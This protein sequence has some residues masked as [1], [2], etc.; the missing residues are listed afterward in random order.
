MKTV[1]KLEIVF[2]ENGGHLLTKVLINGKKAMLVVDTGAS[3]TVFD[4]T[5]IK[6]Y[7]KEKMVVSKG[8]NST[9]LGTSTM[10]SHTHYLKPHPTFLTLHYRY[11]SLL[12]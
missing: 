1:L 3:T 5:E 11:L 2:I 9:G 8:H 12:L 10:K 6:K 4:K 7:V